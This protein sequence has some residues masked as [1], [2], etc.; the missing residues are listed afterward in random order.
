MPHI[1]TNE[2]QEIHPTETEVTIDLEEA[3]DDVEVILP[4]PSTVGGSIFTVNTVG[5]PKKK[6][7]IKANGDPSVER[8]LS[9]R[10]QGVAY[11]SDGSSYWVVSEKEGK[12]SKD[13]DSLK[14]ALRKNNGGKK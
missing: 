5:D 11:Y 6:A 10:G 14:K 3:E 7:T 8:E 1:R 13:E 12:S 9:K 2:T 4:P